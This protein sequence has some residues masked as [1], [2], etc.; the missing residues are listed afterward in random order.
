MNPLHLAYSTV[1]PWPG[2]DDG[3]KVRQRRGMA[4]AAMV[5]IKRITM[6]FL[7]PSQSGKGNY[8]VSL[9]GTRCCSCPDYESRQKDC[10]HIYAVLFTLQ[11]EANPD[12]PGFDRLTASLQTTKYPR[13]W[14]AYNRAKTS[15]MHNIHEMLSTLC[16]SVPQPPRSR[17][18]PRMRFSDMVFSVA[19]KVYRGLSSRRFNGDLEDAQSDGLIGTTPHFN[20]VCK[21]MASPELTETLHDL[22]A[23][24]SLPLVGVEK[25]FAIDSTGFSTCRTVHWYKR[26]HEGFADHKEW[27]KAHFVCGT[28]TKIVTAVEVSDWRAH[29]TRYFKPLLRDT[30]DEFDVQYISADKAYLSRQNVNLAQSIGATPLIPFKTNTVPPPDDG[31]AWTKM[32]YFYTLYRDD[33]LDL[34]HK[35]SNVE[36][37]VQMVKNN[38]GEKLLSK[39]DVGQENELLCKFLCHNLCVLNMALYTMGIDLPFFQVR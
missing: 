27:R 32:W 33:F 17:G 4:I 24:T 16:A 7:V 9:E 37:A 34:Y 8:T 26:Q 10:K 13:D 1:A 28:K 12:H 36:S 38:H 15:E 5:R 25:E 22:I 3:D 18:K 20:T 14:T 30:N 19:S 6:G 39:S 23:V 11:R 31:S 2:Q 21:Y 29:D 35:R